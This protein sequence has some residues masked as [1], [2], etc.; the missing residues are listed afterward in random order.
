MKKETNTSFKS[1]SFEI[2]ELLLYEAIT[3]TSSEEEILE[4]YKK[5]LLTK[6]REDSMTEEDHRTLLDA[7][8]VAVDSFTL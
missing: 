1:I 4:A 3:E 8:R 5:L 7:I 2:N 6:E